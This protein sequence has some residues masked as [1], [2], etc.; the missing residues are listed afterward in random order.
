M[1][2]PRTSCRRAAGETLSRRSLRSTPFAW[3]CV[4]SRAYSSIHTQFGDFTSVHFLSFILILLQVQLQFPRHP[5]RRDREQAGNNSVIIPGLQSHWAK[6][7][8]ER[9][10]LWKMRE[11]HVDLP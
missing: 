6:V 7:A 11:G 4:H 3:R 9:Y 1:D 8:F 2:A 10:F 5:S